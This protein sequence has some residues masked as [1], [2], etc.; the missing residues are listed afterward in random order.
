MCFLRPADSMR[1]PMNLQQLRVRVKHHFLCDYVS[2]L[3]RLRPRV[4]TRL[5]FISTYGLT[6]KCPKCSS[7]LPTPLPACAKCWS[8]SAIPNDTSFHEIFS[9]PPDANVFKIDTSLLKQRF[10]E[11]QSICHPDTWASKGEVSQ[12]R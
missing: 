5:R 1:L 4:F 12:V 8:I 3:F 6:R 2:M 7:P 9:L 11:A 10:R